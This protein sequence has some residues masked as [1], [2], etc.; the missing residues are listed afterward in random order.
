MLVI[1]YAMGTLY[2]RMHV[3]LRELCDSYRGILLILQHIVANDTTS[4]SWAS[5]A[6][7]SASR[8]TTLPTTSAGFSATWPRAKLC[9]LP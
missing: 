9:R 5:A 8:R 2:E 4:I 7:S 6:R 3:N 1:A